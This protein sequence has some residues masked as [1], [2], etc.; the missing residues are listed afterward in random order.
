[1]RLGFVF[2]AFALAACTPQP[3]A[4]A[5]DV[6]RN[7]VTA[8]EAQGSAG[9]LCTCV[10]DRI[11][12]EIPPGDFT[13]LERLPGPQRDA[14]PLT[15]QIAGYVEACNAGLAPQVEPGADAVVPEP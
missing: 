12:T 2:A 13:A 3:A 4:Y 9:A 8:C 6:E 14:H 1:M 15:A 11:E 7:F 10:W 5:P